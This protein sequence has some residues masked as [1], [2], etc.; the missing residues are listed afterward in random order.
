MLS[1][2]ELKHALLHARLV[3][4]I[5]PLHDVKKSASHERAEP[6]A[7]FEH[8]AGANAS[9]QSLA[10]PCAGHPKRRVMARLPGGQPKRQ[11]KMVEPDGIEPT[12]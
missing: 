10:K 9:E 4:G 12:T 11:R 5:S 7:L 1:G 2:D 6:A 3:P 8:G